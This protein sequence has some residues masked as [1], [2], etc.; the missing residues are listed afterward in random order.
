[1]ARAPVVLSEYDPAWPLNFEEEKQFL[2]GVIGDYL[3]GSIEHV[4]STAVTGLVAKPVI[5]IM[6]GVKT[7]RA[8]RPAI[9]AL[10]S[11][12]YVYSPYKTDVM[13]WFCKPSDAHRTHH[14]HL[15]PH[16]SALWRERI[17]FRDLLRSEAHIA[18]QYADLKRQLAVRYKDDREAY[19]EKKWPFIRDALALD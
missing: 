6:F 19:T 17:K 12:G 11:A 3:S 8:S 4:G 1:M 5:D 2:S 9:D 7:L 15:I 14:L 13:H 16:E 18:N 10:E